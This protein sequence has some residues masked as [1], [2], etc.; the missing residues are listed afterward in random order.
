M[1]SMVAWSSDGVMV[2][3]WCVLEKLLKCRDLDQLLNNLLVGV[4]FILRIRSS[5][6][7]LHPFDT[8]AAID[9]IKLNPFCKQSCS[10]VA[11]G[12]VLTLGHVLENVILLLCKSDR[13]CVVHGGG[14]GASGDGLGEAQL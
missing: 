9:E 1:Q 7:I 14:G 11:K 3:N 13:N 2:I 5:A 12:S 6:I 8:N 4:M 10:H